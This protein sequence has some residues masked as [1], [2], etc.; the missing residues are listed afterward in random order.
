MKLR[1]ILTT[2]LLSAAALGASLSS[3]SA[4]MTYNTGDLFLGFRGEGDAQ[5]YLVNIGNVSQFANLGPGVKITVTTGGNIRL[6]LVEAFGSD[7]H[8]RSDV[9][10]GVIGTTF[11]DN[12]T[13]AVIYASK[14]RSNPAIPSTPWIGGSPSGQI[15]KASLVQ[16]LIFKY[17]QDGTATANSSKA[18]FQNA[19][20]ENSWADL[21]SDIS[22]FRVGGSIEGYFSLETGTSSSVLDL[23]QINPGY[24]QPAKLLGSFTIDDNGVITFTA[25]PEPATLAMLALAGLVLAFVVNRR[26]RSR[27]F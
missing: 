10:W 22:D 19:S 12:T 20:S 18:T 6:D 7:W 26:P 14:Q 9:Y 17:V 4:V 21:T 23:Y 1:P 11:V 24:G 5:N 3:A 2:F 15:E 13:P 16:E 25:V 8:S 27:K